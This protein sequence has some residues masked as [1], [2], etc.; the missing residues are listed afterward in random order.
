[1]EQTKKKIGRPRSFD[2]NEAL[3]CAIEV[4]F[5]KGFEGTSLDDLTKR[6]SIN[7]PSL[8]SAFENK[9]RLFLVALDRYHEVYLH[10]FSDLIA[11]ELP[12]KETIKIWLAWFIENYQSQE[13]PF[14][15]L[16]VNSTTL[17]K[18]EYPAITNHLTKFHDLNEQLLADYFKTAI[19][20]GEL[21]KGTDSQA[22]SQ[23]YNA[24]VQGMAVLRRG[25][26]KMKAVKNIAAE[27]MKNFPED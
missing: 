26:G 1:M 20:R 16:I 21:K 13:V 9:E 17:C 5:E 23:F 4:F 7:R 12:A 3:D 25:Q 6:L 8:Y 10:F 15:C 11:K 22:L 14:G 2:K 27:A 24:I 18:S 19:K